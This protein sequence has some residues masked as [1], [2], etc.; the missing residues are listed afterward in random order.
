VEEH[1][2]LVE[3]GSLVAVVVDSIGRVRFGLEVEMKGE[4]HIDAAELE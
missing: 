4:E 2:H 1:N 3:L